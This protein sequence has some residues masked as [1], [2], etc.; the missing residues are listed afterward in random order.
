MFYSLASTTAPTT[1]RLTTILVVEI[2]REDVFE[3]HSA[4][5]T[6]GTSG[7][8]ETPKQQCIRLTM[9][10]I[11]RV[12]GPESGLDK[13]ELKQAA[14]YFKFLEAKFFTKET[15]RY[16]AIRAFLE[17]KE[18]IESGKSTLYF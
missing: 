8:A 15:D 3:I 6:S 14:E 13:N 1:V 10:L 11:A 12:Y 18:C 9:A 16:L 4:L 2:G 5:K 7:K 17:G